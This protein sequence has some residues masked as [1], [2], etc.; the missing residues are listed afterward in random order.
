MGGAEQQLHGHCGKHRLPAPHG[1]GS[2]GLSGL[3]RFNILAVRCREKMRAT[4]KTLGHKL[5]FT[6]FCTLRVGWGVGRQAGRATEGGCD[7]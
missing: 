1:R 7:P 6:C 4:G 2:K 3:G 5:F